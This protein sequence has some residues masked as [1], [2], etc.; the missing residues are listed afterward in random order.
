MYGAT[1]GQDQLTKPR[2]MA[3]TLGLAVPQAEAVSR[4]ELG[5]IP[6]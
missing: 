2:R 3:P 5:V 1:G 6:E 4:A